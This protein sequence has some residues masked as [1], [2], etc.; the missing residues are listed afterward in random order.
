[1]RTM[2]ELTCE[3]C[4]AKFN[5]CA[6]ETKRNKKKG[7]KV[8]CNNRCQ[9]QHPDND[10]KLIKAQTSPNRHKWTSKTAPRGIFKDEFSNFR[11]YMTNVRRSSKKRKYEY[12]ID[13][14]YLKN[15]WEI[16]KGICPL[17]GWELVLKSHTYR[18]NEKM[19]IHHASLDRIDSKKGY[20]KGN[21]RFISIMANYA[22]HKWGDDDLIEFCNAVHYH[23]TLIF[24]NRLLYLQ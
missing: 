12:D 23:Q 19:T 15:L 14:N 24:E 6:S 2:T 11:W 4:G 22:K 20:I 13:L 3:S 8:F 18:P 5:R 16:Q 10:A 1:M 9:A 7:R 21:V 17:T